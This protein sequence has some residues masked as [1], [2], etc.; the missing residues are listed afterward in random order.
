[1]LFDY[2]GLYMEGF[3][4]T[5]FAY[6]L[7]ILIN[8]IFGF[9]LPNNTVENLYRWGFKFRRTGNHR[10]VYTIHDYYKVVLL[11][12]FNKHYNGNIRW[13][14]ITCVELVYEHYCINDISYY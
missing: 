2:S 6:F 14:D 10:I 11:H 12:N 13:E 3:I 9:S 4:E 1:M 8:D 5:I 7:S